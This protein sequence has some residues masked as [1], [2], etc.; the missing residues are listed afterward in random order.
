[1]LSQRIKGPGHPDETPG[2]GA[3][4]LSGKTPISQYRH[5][6]DG[7]LLRERCDR[8]KQILPCYKIYPGVLQELCGT[9]TCDYKNMLFA[10]E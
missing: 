3:S 10:D 8:K 6:P 7:T 9:D 4:P 5:F 2:N 1:M